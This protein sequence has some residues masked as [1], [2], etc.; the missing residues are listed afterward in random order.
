MKESKVVEQSKAAYGQWC[1]QWR[2][3]AVE[4]SKYPMKSLEDF[5][6]VGLGKAVLCV[7]N[8]YSFE[9]NI[10]T[11][12]KHRHN[13]DILCCDKTLG[14]LIENGIYPDFCIVCDAKVNYDK[15]LKPWEDKLSRTVLLIN[16]CAN[17]LWTKNGN[18]K[19]KYFFVNKDAIK[20]EVEFCKLSGCPNIIP[21]GTNVSNA[22]VIMLTQ[23]DNDGRRNFFGYDK[24]LLIGF[25]YSWR[26]GGKYYAFNEDGGGKA[27]YMKHAY[28]NLPDGSFGYTSGNL[29]FS[30]EWFESYVKTFNLPVVQCSKSTILRLKTADLDTQMQYRHKPENAVTLKKQIR[31]MREALRKVK[32]HEQIIK[33]L[34]REH[35]NAFLASV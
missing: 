5:R 15:Y 31:E 1:K 11:I 32:M 23:C 27:S 13:V 17:P 4:H 33:G 26:F 10:E 16:V 7:A 8:G 35:W 28:V 14:S 22:M 34:E 3:H 21:A 20:T 18:W 19:D 12:K 2:E 25:D 6:G 24:I 9:E 30:A 29:A